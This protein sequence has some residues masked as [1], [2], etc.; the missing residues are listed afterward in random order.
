[1][2]KRNYDNAL[3][4][5]NENKQKNYL[6]ESNDILIKEFA[7]ALAELS[8]MGSDYNGRIIS[9]SEVRLIEENFLKKIRGWWGNLWNPKAKEAA[10]TSAR[11]L[12]EL[13]T[14]TKGIGKIG[15]QLGRQTADAPTRTSQEGDSKAR[16]TGKASKEA[17]EA[18][19]RTFGEVISVAGANAKEPKETKEVQRRIE[20]RLE[21]LARMYASNK[22]RQAEEENE[23]EV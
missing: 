1:M 12:M 15:R 13:I 10:E 18:L 23:E 4:R 11:V 5:L 20:T 21:S 7:S 3:T 22:A 14:G 16:E 19:A 8:M 2:D 6:K 17:S 9:E